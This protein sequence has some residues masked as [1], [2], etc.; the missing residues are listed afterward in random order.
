MKH[1]L[2]L[3]FIPGFLDESRMNM[4]RQTYAG[5]VD[6]VE[7]IKSVD[8]YQNALERESNADLLFEMELANAEVLD[9]YLKHPLHVEFAEKI[10]PF[11]TKMVTF[12]Y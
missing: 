9:I 7:G 2:L 8:I 11:I 1:Y 6:A 5:V 3:K 12:D 4:I 10:M